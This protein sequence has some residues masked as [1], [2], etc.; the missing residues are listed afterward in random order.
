MIIEHPDGVGGQCTEQRSV[1]R[2]C[3]GGCGVIV[4]MRDGVVSEL[5]GDPASP[6]SEG[7]F[8]TKGKA[9]LELLTHPA[10][11]TEPLL[12]RG[13]KHIAMPWDEALDM[14][15][16]RIG[17]QI[18]RHGAESVVLSQ[19]TDRNYQEWV[20]RFA[21][22]LGTPNVL[23]PAH[24]CFYPRVMASIL[25]CG[26]F[27]FCDYEG[28]PEL[29]ILWGSNKLHTHSDGLIGVKLAKA[30]QRGARLVVIDPR[31]NDQTRRADLWL[32]I[33]PGSD[34]ALALGMLHVMI[35]EGWYDAGFVAG[36]TDGFAELAEHVRSYDPQRVAGLTG[37]D[38]GQVVALAS[39]YGQAGRACIEAGT[40]LSQNE[41]AFSTLRSICI[42]SAL[43]GNL[44][45][46]GGDVLWDLLPVDGRRSFPL[47]ERLAPEQQAKRLG[48]GAYPVLSMAGWA[49]PDA[50][51]DAM[52]DAQPYAVKTLLNFGS[53]LPMVYADAQRVHRALRGLE[54]HMT[55]DLFMTPTAQLADLVLPVGSW[56]ERDQIVEF[57]A[58]LAPRRKLA[59]VGQCR[60]DEE[61]ILGLARRL[62]LGQHFWPNLEA[63]LDHKLA[64]IGHTW[65][66][67]KQHGPIANPPHYRKYA[68]EGFR[69][70][71]GRVN[72]LHPGLPRMGGD[73]LPQY[74]PGEALPDGHFRM[75]SAHSRNFYNSEYRQLESLRKREPLPRVQ[76]HPQAAAALGIVAGD[77][78][79]VR[80]AGGSARFCADLF[81][82][83]APDVVYVAPSWWYPEEEGADNWQRSNANMLTGRAARASEMGTS[84]FRNVAVQL[85]KIE[86][87][88]S[89]AQ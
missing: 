69:T 67:F 87:D 11:L 33:R 57:N 10:R 75:S 52:L 5:K 17:E 50:V 47:A 19:G 71:S 80:S 60:S 23:G 68:T 26:G 13:D 9:S 86:K 89:D 28:E 43:S 84:N 29:I 1:C 76:I 20:F 63:A 36:H 12:R 51:W 31:A 30:L 15:A 18:A 44:D 56:L 62:G 66:S 14:A 81:D 53:N 34:G 46:P 58:Y 64:G 16:H 88:D 54:F 32:Q 39:A 48:G 37:L 70:R 3:H 79:L 6:A 22:T 2:M 8:C 83:V 45:A 49:H 55:C 41:N 85:E 72:L 65:T 40:G 82:G 42:L 21:N 7:F 77:W 59:Q 25:T 78:V 38:A 74:R 24:V 73:A 35:K 4:Q 27:T 61:I